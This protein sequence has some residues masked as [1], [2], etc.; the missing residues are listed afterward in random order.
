MRKNK[1]VDRKIEFFYLLP[2][3]ILSAHSSSGILNYMRPYIA[4]LT[5]GSTLFNKKNGEQWLESKFLFYIATISYA[6][7]VLHGSLSNTWLGSGEVM[8]KY[9]KRPLLLVTVF[10]LSHMSTFYYEKYWVNFSKKLLQY[11][12]L[13]KA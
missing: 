12:I 8:E 5:I 9:I 4:M 1:V 7:Y 11:R 3:L 6:L 2:L 10:L 13:K